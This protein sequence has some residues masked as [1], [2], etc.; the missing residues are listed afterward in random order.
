MKTYRN[1]FYKPEQHLNNPYINEFITP[2]DPNPMKYNG[3]EIYKHSKLQYDIVK[4]GVCLSMVGSVRYAKAHIDSGL[5]H[6]KTV[7]LFK[8][9]Y[10]QAL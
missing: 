10:S 7:Q 9:L 1:S 6:V 2:S 8:E 4:D 3:Y 5:D